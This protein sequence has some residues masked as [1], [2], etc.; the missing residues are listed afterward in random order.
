MFYLTQPHLKTSIQPQLLIFFNYLNLGLIVLLAT[1]G[2][3]KH[4]GLSF[5]LTALLGGLLTVL[6][7]LSPQYKPKRLIAAV[8]LL[9]ALILAL[10]ISW[11]ELPLIGLLLGITGIFALVPL[12]YPNQFNNQILRLSFQLLLTSFFYLITQIFSTI[13]FLPENLLVE[14]GVFLVIIYLFEL[15]A[16]NWPITIISYGF[17]AITVI[18]IIL[19]HF[20]HGGHLIL[21]AGGQLLLITLQ[22]GFINHSY[23]LQEVGYL[24]LIVGIFS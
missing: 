8:T 10:I 11:H 3:P 22:L 13:Q 14:I 2:F 4:L 17:W 24:L 7:V 15:T 19:I 20:I 12:I 18:T 9:F 21:F 1:W 6:L 16:R 5:Y 23:Y